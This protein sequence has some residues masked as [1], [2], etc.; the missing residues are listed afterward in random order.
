MARA[1]RAG[2]REWQREWPSRYKCRGSLAAPEE[3]SALTPVDGSHVGTY[4]QVG[5]L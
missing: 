5:S 2:A 4:R 1:C 3:P